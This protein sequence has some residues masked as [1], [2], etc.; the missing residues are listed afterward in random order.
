MYVSIV[1]SHWLPVVLLNCFSIVSVHV[2]ALIL[3]VCLHSDAY[4]SLFGSSC[5]GFGFV[6]SDLDICM[7]FKGKTI[8][9][10]FDVKSV[11]FPV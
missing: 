5:N 10:R 3:C 6:W 8:E 11:W 1:D 7:A 9:V 2:C 4:F